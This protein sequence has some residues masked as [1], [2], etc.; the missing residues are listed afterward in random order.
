MFNA[1]DTIERAV[2]SALAQT[3][4]P[5]EIIVVDDCSIDNT[6]DILSKLSAV[7]PELRIFY[8]RNNVGVAASRN[9]ILA[10]ARG[11]FIAFFDDDDE[12]LPERVTVQLDRILSYERNFAD[13]LPVICHTAR[14][15][16]YPD[17]NE[18]IEHT[19]G[20]QEGRIAPHGMAV[21]EHIILGTRLENDRGACPTCSQMARLTTYQTVNCFDPDF[22]RSEDT[23][24]NVRL[25]KTGGHFAG[26]ARPLVRQIMTRG[27][28]KNLI[29][30]RRYMKMLLEKHRDIADKY[31]MYSFCQCW[32]NIKYDWL[33]RN[34]LNFVR[35]II[36]LAL[37]HPMLFFKRTVSALP[38]IWLN[39]SFSRFHRQDEV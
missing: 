34:R 18:R 2:S 24:L 36:R 10:E 22:R 32:L 11:E 16:L 4:R 23:E 39:Q 7:H 21:A 30:E 33:M 35:G 28:D 29:Y 37:A 6:N 26:I 3:W 17:G 1:E 14:I 12:S 31:G 38:N 5:I 9:R 20:E 25:A 27:V 19:M 8:N 15:V 13:G